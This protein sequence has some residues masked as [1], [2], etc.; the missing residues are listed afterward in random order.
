MIPVWYWQVGIIMLVVHMFFFGVAFAL[1]TKG[2]DGSKH[3][4]GLI[5]MCLLLGVA[6]V[7]VV[8]F[9]WGYVAADVIKTRQ[10][11]SKEKQG[12]PT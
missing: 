2:F 6:W 7:A 5:V 9:I 1:S 10:D 3:L 4:I 8:P 11:K 12:T